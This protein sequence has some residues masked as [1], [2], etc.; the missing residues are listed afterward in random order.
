MI[1][2]ATDRC[3]HVRTV[4]RHLTSATYGELELGY[5][6]H[7]ETI[8]GRRVEVKGYVVFIED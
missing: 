6:D 4:K 2:P 7:W 1:R 3:T 5:V 8:D